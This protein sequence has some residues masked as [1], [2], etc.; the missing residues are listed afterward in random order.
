M[1]EHDPG[2]TFRADQEAAQSRDEKSW[3]LNVRSSE[4][5]AMGAEALAIRLL[6]QAKVWRATAALIT[7]VVLGSA[8][9]VLTFLGIGRWA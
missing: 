5:Q 2:A 6:S 1:S 7:V 8:A 9:F 3:E 4:A